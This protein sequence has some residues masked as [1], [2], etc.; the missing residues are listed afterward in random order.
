MFFQSESHIIN[1]NKVRF[2]DKKLGI[3]YMD[4]DYTLQLN[5][6]EIRTFLW[7]WEKV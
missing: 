2:I 5:E 7:H 3:L 6:K 1:V 4:G